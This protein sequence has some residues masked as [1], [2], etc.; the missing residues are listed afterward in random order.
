MALIVTSKSHLERD[1]EALAELIAERIICNL[2][3]TY[4]GFDALAG[5]YDFD[6]ED[7]R[8]FKQ[9]YNH[10]FAAASDRLSTLTTEQQ[11]L[12]CE[13]GEFP[14]GWETRPVID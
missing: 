4:R 2:T 1:A 14:E 5:V 11:K 6:R 8:K 12:F 9:A 13:N 10:Y 7:Q 3:P